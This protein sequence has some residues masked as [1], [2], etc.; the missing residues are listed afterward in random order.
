MGLVIDSFAGAGGA[1]LGIER[2]IGRSPD[3]AINHDAAALR[4]HEANHPKTRHVLE[5]V[6]VADLPGLVGNESVD[7]L[8]ASPDCRHF[9]RAKGS[10]PVSKSVRSLAWVVCKWASKVEPEIIVL[11][12]V[13]EF[14]DWGPLIPAWRCQECGWRGTEG[15]AVLVRTRRKCPRCES[16]S[17]RM[18]EDLI[19]DPTRK[20]LT[21]RRFIGRLRNL[22]YAVEWRSLNA[23]DFGAP[24]HRRRLFVIAR[25]DGNPIE[26]PEPTHCDPDK[27]GDDPLFGLPL[28]PWRTAAECIDWDVPCPSI[29][30][31]KRP[32]AEKTLRRI[33][34]GIKRYILENPRPFIVRYNGARSPRDFRGQEITSP[35][36]TSDTQP[37]FGLTTPIMIPLTHHGDRRSHELTEPVPTIT[38]AKRG[39]VAVVDPMRTLTTGN[40]A[41]LVYSFLVKYFGTAIGQLVDDP[42]HAVTSKDRFGVVTVNVDGELYAIV[43]IGMRMLLPRELARAQG[44]P[45]SYVLTGSKTCQVASIGNSVS[46]VVAEAVVRANMRVTA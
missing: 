22:G 46:P 42:L 35:F 41:V 24:T 15:Q 20:G 16:R 2:A 40:H 31:R 32:L 26:W 33:A 34:L 30:D 6:H 10:K 29:F 14:A 21:F 38:T 4:M 43:D 27:V 45:D 18:T 12:N 8:W 37:R 36:T 7:F 1:S 11:E 9:S 44:F 28:K 13:R 3:I 23:A 17:L 19:P 5:D 39:E 25:R